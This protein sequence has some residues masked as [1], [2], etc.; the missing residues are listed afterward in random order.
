MTNPI[1]PRLRPIAQV[2]SF[3]CPDDSSTEQIA[4][5]VDKLKEMLVK[6]GGESRTD[7]LNDIALRQLYRLE[8]ILC[9]R[10]WHGCSNAT[11]MR[12]RCASMQGC[13]LRNG[14]AAERTRSK[15]LQR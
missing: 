12:V 14:N 5:V 7:P 2:E 11:E 10:D 9:R 3:V 1:S 4:F 15:S 8:W 13:C 6:I